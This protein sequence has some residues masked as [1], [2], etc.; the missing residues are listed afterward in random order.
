MTKFCQ[1]DIW[2]AN[3]NPQFKAEPGKT[4]PVLIIQT[5]HFLNI[6]HSTTL[7]VP[8][9]TKLINNVEPLRLRI[10]ASGKLEKD[11]D[12]LIDQMRSIDN[13]RFTGEKLLNIGAERLTNVLVAINKL[14][15]FRKPNRFLN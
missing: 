7:I 6:G 1:G 2:L 13:S 9:T 4:R 5:Q 10:L 3:L 12:L 11:S 15:S 14:I 8:L